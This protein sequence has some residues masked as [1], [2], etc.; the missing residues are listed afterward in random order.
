MLDSPQ[1]VCA[2]QVE[3]EYPAT[4]VPSSKSAYTAKEGQSNEDVRRIVE[5]LFK[6]CRELADWL[7]QN[8]NVNKST[9]IGLIRRSPSLRLADAM[10]QTTK[11]HT[12]RSG[13]DDPITA[14]ITESASV[15]MALGPDQLV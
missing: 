6:T 7:W 3:F 1:G 13:K 2:G 4:S 9:V 11:H 14:R 8:T 10:A 5:D 12:R 15:L